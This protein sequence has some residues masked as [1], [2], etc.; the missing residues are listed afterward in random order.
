MRERA[1]SLGGVIEIA[2]G[3]HGGT[4][5][6]LTFP[7]RGTRAA[8]AG[9]SPPVHTLMTT[10]TRTTV[11]IIDD[12]P[13]FR[14]GV[15]DLIAMAPELILVGEAGD[16]EEGVRVAAVPPGPDP[17]RPQHEGHERHPD[18]G[19]SA[20]RRSGRPGRHADRLR[21]R[22]GRG[23]RLRAGADGYL[24]KDM[25]PEDILE[26]LLAAGRGRLVISQR[27]PS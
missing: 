21:Q 16:G 8:E 17:A 10:D 18:P 12:H 20:P 9:P 19:A 27:S 11:V 6:R 24:L 22:G 13:L 2:P 5:V 15:S 14:K 4:R 23:R 1:A 25:E 3:P 26:Q 7:S